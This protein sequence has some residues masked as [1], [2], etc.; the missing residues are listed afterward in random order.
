MHVMQT[1]VTDDRGVCQA[2][3]LSHSLTRL[4]CAKMAEQIKMLFGVNTPGSPCNIVL[5]GGHDPTTLRG[6]VTYF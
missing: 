5:D 6:R 4:H 2:V 3:C 1:I